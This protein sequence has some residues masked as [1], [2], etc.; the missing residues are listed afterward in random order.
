MALAWAR[1][2]PGVTSLLMGARTP[3]QLRR[4]LGSL[5]LQLEPSVVELLC[6]AGTEGSLCSTGGTGCNSFVK[7]CVPPAPAYPFADLLAQ[8][9]PTCNSRQ[10][11]G[12]LRCCGHKRIMLD[13]DQE[14]RDG[15]RLGRR[16]SYARPHSSPP[17]PPPT[18]TTISTSASGCAA[19][20]SS[21]RQTSSPNPATPGASG[22]PH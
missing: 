6:D 1:E 3:E 15:T 14:V 4:N 13:A 8:R 21:S 7:N 5:K 22:A 18:G 10:Y 12:G 9:N 20:S 17:A 19:S 2:R 16:A 11:A